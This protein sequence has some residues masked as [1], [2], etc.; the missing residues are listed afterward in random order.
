MLVPPKLSVS[1]CWNDA[2]TL[3]LKDK[4]TRMKPL[5]TLDTCETETKVYR[6]RDLADLVSADPVQ[7]VSIP[8]MMLLQWTM[9]RT[10]IVQF[11]WLPNAQSSL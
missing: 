7:V 6:E 9:R 10:F 3:T 5:Q 8:I 2:G 4:M 11:S 1:V